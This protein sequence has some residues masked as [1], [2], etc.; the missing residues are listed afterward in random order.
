MMSWIYFSCCL[1]VR[2]PEKE[3]QFL[4]KKSEVTPQC[5]NMALHLFFFTVSTEHLSFIFS[6]KVLPR[7]PSLIPR[8][9]FEIWLSTLILLDTDLLN[10]RKIADKM[11]PRT[12]KLH[13]QVEFNI[14]ISCSSNISIVIV[15]IYLATEW[16]LKNVEGNI[17]SNC[18]I[19]EKME[20][21][22]KTISISNQQD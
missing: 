21:E 5:E 6:R 4:A 11:P 15:Y 2:L 8:F 10:S 13:L 19:I 7:H 18:S 3:S 16:E 1:M 22:N 20:E 17:K 14:T 9:Q 12:L